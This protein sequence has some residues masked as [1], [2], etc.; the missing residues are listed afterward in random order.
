MKYFWIGIIALIAFPS[1]DKEDDAPFELTAE[2]LIGTWEHYQSQGNTGG[3]D[4]WTP[5][6]PSGRT[7]TFFPSGKFSTVDYF[8]CSEGEFTVADKNVTFLFDCEEHVAELN[9]SMRTKEGDLVLSPGL[10][11]ICIEGCSYIFKKIE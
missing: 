7:I 6:E 4:Y 1:C 9:Y 5:Y 3:G 11:Y 8:G 10:P 2:G